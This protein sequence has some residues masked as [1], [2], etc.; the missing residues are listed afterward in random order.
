MRRLTLIS[1]LVLLAIPASAIQMQ[2][3][4]EAA[5]EFVNLGSQTATDTGTGVAIVN[6]S[7][8]GPGHLNTLTLTTNYA[9]IDG[10][11]DVTDPIVTAGGI[12]EIR[13]TSLKA[14]PSGAG[15]RGGSFGPISGALQNTSLAGGGTLASSGTVRLCLF[16]P[17]CTGANLS[18]SLAQTVNGVR[19]GAGIGG[20]VTIGAFGPIR[21]SLLGAPW[22]VKT[23]SISNRT[24]NEGITFFARNGFAHGPASLTS[25]TAVT[26]GVV[27]LVSPNQQTVQGVPGN[28]DKGGTITRSTIRFIPEPGL[29]ALLGAGAAG[30][31]LL[32][33]SRRRR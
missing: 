10:V 22:T 14:Q 12:V 5:I 3:V 29:L 32:G 23:A 18:S 13:L 19:T 16:V 7:S 31:V 4:G 11:I 20:V 27:Q 26:S 21:V 15:G 9:T 33:R 30:V 8:G 25:S 24:D 2:F 1:T 6:G 28:S 17:G